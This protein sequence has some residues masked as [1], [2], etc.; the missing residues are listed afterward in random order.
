MKLRFNE[1]LLQDPRR[2]LIPALRE[3]IGFNNPPTSLDKEVTEN[4]AK[5]I[6]E[7][8]ISEVALQKIITYTKDLS[9]GLYSAREVVGL[10]ESA[11]RHVHDFYIEKSGES[12]D[13]YYIDPENAMGASRSK[14]L[15][16]RRGDLR[17]KV[18]II[19]A[20]RIHGA[21]QSVPTVALAR[22]L[23][24]A[25]DDK[26][27]KTLHKT[28]QQLEL[29]RKML[30][31][32]KLPEF[33]D[34]EKA[35]HLSFGLD[36]RPSYTDGFYNLRYSSQEAKSEEDLERTLSDPSTGKVSLLGQL[37]RYTS[38]MRTHFPRLLEEGR[39]EKTFIKI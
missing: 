1:P 20:T 13:L 4:E 37:S 2:R 23:S 10:P 28:S 19:F 35:K 8:L 38:I 6:I 25:L 32:G 7:S 26:H 24:K 39:F 11:T 33:L 36:I 17:P 14:V 9:D 16:P 15:L 27:D 31:T 18:N 29:G 22:Y 30:Q 3:K 12:L 34:K 21:G 5:R